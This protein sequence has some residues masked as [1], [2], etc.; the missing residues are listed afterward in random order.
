MSLENDF[1]IVLA[2]QSQQAL[3]WKTTQI[4]YMSTSRPMY[5]FIMEAKCFVRHSDALPY[6]RIPTSESLRAA[7]IAHLICSARSTARRFNS[8]VQVFSPARDLD[9]QESCRT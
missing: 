7:G 9:H 2:C 5:C 1:M 8:A 4:S 3:A 6:F